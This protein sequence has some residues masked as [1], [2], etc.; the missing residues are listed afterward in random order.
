MQPE[1]ALTWA[2]EPEIKRSAYRPQEY[3]SA[4][5]KDS[6]SLV[7]SP[8]MHSTHVIVVGTRRYHLRGLFIIQ[9]TYLDDGVST[10]HRAI[11]VEGF[12][13]TQ[14]ESMDDFFE[15]FDFQY[16]HLVEVDEDTLTVG[17]RER[18]AAIEHV[19]S[20]VD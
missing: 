16:R 1:G 12:G 5:A 14:K 3:A 15:Q 7:F 13:S 10:R 6:S 20:K 4:E 19:V 2:G 8:A 9:F 18:R 17:G 11:P